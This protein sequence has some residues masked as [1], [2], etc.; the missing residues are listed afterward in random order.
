M[1]DQ[2]VK[3]VACP[4]LAASMFDGETI[5]LN[6]HDGNYYGLNGVGAEV[7]RW[8]HEPK[9]LDQ[10]ESMITEHFDVESG[11]ARRDV[12]LLIEDLYA[13]KLIE[14]AP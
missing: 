2:S 6:L 5:L 14:V 3:Y 10:L 1:I 7:W 13:R 4:N 8:L 12:G 9:T 11:T